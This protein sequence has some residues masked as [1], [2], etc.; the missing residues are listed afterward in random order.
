M[1]RIITLCFIMAL[2]LIA[3]IVFIPAAS[4][5]ES[6][7]LQNEAAETAPP[8]Q[9]QPSRAQQVTEA[10]AAAYPGR[11]MRA[12]FRGDDWA[13]LLRDTW[14]Y[15]AEGR[16]MPEE[17]LHRASE[18]RPIAFYNNYHRELPPW[19]APSPEEVSRL[20]EITGSRAASRPRSPYFFDALYRARSRDESNRRTKTLRFLVIPDGNA[21]AMALESGA[22]HMMSGR[23]ALTALENLRRLNNIQIIKTMSQTSELIMINTFDE[24]LGDVNVR[25][26]V[27][28]AVDFPGVVPVLLTDLA[29]PPVNFFSPGFGRFVDPDFQLPR[30]DPAAAVEYLKAAGFAPG[31]LKLEMLLDARNEENNALAVVMQEQ[32]RAVGIELTITLI[33]YAALSARVSGPGRD[34]QMAMRGQYFIP[35]DDPSIH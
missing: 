13:V 25:R 14:F 15:Y 10:L 21:R 6:P 24:T 12:E 31:E 20:Q 27:A 19:T 2:A 32:L 26:A 22:I 11:V 3:G 1:F 23:G 28:A 17:L 16:L 34:F 33:D 4:R 29:E 30:Y 7:A 8:E 5:A 35:T 18:Y 9:E